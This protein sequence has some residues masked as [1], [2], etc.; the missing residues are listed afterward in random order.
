MEMG[1]VVV[2]AQMPCFELWVFSGA[3]PEVGRRRPGE[4]KSKAQAG[5]K[6]EREVGRPLAS[7]LGRVSLG[8]GM[9]R[10]NVPMSKNKMGALISETL[11]TGYIA[12]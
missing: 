10:T 11:T 8:R 6:D 7:L 2:M 9:G 12:H 4:R 1:G 3:W 5:R